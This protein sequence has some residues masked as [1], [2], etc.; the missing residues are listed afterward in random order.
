VDTRSESH[1]FLKVWINPGQIDTR[2]SADRGADIQPMGPLDRAIVGAVKP[3]LPDATARRR[4][5]LE[6]KRPDIEASERKAMCSGREV[7]QFGAWSNSTTA[8]AGIDADGIH[9][10]VGPVHTTCHRE[11][12]LRSKIARVNHHGVEPRGPAPWATSAWANAPPPTMTAQRRIM[13]RHKCIA[14]FSTPDR[15]IEAIR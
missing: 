7:V 13:D 4:G 6:P 14:V 2:F 5:P 15:S 3:A 11:T 10:R 1:G 8:L 12:R 9:R